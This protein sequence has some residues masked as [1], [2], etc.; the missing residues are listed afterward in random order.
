M[1]KLFKNYTLG[2][3]EH[4]GQRITNEIGDTFTGVYEFKDKKRI[5]FFRL[6]ETSE[7][8]LDYKEVKTIWH[9]QT[10]I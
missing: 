7:E 2:T 8:R 5:P 6:F 10:T 1:A 3:P 9:S 4:T